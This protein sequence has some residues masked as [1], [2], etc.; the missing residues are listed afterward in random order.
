MQ[1]RK[2]KTQDWFHP[3]GFPIAL[4]RR[5]PQE[6][7]GLHMH[8]FAELVIITGGHGLHVTGRQSWPLSSG[9][10]FVLS[11]SRPHDY[12]NMDHLCLINLLFQLD[13]LHLEL[14]DLPTL[15]GYHALFSLEPA[16]RRRHQFKSR[17]HL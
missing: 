1:A 17:L 11:G 6:P 10:V 16:W 7:F 8:E 12:R 2:L 3:D 15:A 4:E 5:D 14:H 13:K 9:D